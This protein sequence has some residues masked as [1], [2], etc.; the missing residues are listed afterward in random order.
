MKFVFML[1]ICIVLTCLVF[2]I[3]NIVLLKF[4][5]LPFILVPGGLCTYN[6]VAIIKNKKHH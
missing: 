4:V 1:N 3:I 5:L 6:A 2:L